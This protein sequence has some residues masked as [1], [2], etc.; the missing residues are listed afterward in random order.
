MGRIPVRHQPFVPCEKAVTLQ[1]NDSIMLINNALLW[2]KRNH[3]QEF[4]KST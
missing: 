1:R 3:I 4:D 2:A